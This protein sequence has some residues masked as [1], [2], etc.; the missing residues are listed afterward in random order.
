MSTGRAT[1]GARLGAPIVL[2]AAL[3]VALVAG[4]IV[5][6]APTPPPQPPIYRVNIVAAP[7]GP[8]QA[9]V[10]TPKPEPPP[11]KPAPVP[12]RA[13]SNPKA[14]P[15]P[16]KKPPVRR[17]TAPATPVPVPEKPAKPAK[18]QDAPHAGGG[19]TGGRGTDVATVRTDGIEFPYQGYLDNIVRQI[20]VRFQPPTNATV[21]AVVRFLIH[22]DGSVSDIA[23]VTRSGLFEFDLDA[24]GAVEQAG[25]VH[26]FGPLPSGF[27]DDVL[28]VIF[29]FDPR[30]LH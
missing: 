1:Q 20:A 9:G 6:H 5:L 12:P 27:S 18:V 24:Q 16:T 10:V 4:L 23:F 11:A 17:K 13:E 28:P 2:S 7:P 8:R 22:R 25:S 3:H 30:V 26:A 21:R 29:S 14:M 19:P 15:L